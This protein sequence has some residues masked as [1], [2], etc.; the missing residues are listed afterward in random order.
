M[1]DASQFQ[2]ER[3]AQLDTP[4]LQILCQVCNDHDIALSDLRNNIDKLTEDEQRTVA[5]CLE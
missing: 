5:I 4:A 1:L 2:P 3:L